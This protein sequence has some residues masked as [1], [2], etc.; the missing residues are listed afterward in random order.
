MFRRIRKCRSAA[1]PPYIA[2]RVREPTMVGAEPFHPQ[3]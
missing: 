2:A 3:E 1:F